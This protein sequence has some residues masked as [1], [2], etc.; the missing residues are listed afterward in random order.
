MDPLSITASIVGLLA[1]AGKIYTLLEAISTI[2][3]SPT[4]I[5]DAQ[6]EV[7]HTEIAL[8]SMQRLLEKVEVANARRELIQ[9][10]ELRITLADAMLVFSEFES[11]L[12]LLANLSKFR[13]AISW[14]RH[15]KKIDEYLVRI[16]RYKMSLT[17]MLSILQWWV[18]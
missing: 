4:T 18:F 1:A 2:K 3:D 17:F 15:A 16:G 6:N 10:D 9:V 5:T 14:Q 12:L 8:R 13:V 7:K 11:M